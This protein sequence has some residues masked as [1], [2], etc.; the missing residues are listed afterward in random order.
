MIFIQYDEDGTH[1][2]K[3]NNLDELL[4]KHE[5]IDPSE[6]KLYLAEQYDGGGLLPGPAYR[7]DNC[8]IQILINETPV[9]FK[10]VTL[11]TKWGL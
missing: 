3:Y 9:K 4:E 8:A 2:Y 5:W 7:A 1:L 10:P 6:L 11:V